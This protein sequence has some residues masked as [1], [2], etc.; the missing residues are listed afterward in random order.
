MLSTELG[1]PLLKVY[2]PIAFRKAYLNY[3]CCLMLLA[4]HPWPESYCYMG[5]HSA[6]WKKFSSL[7]Q[8]KELRIAARQEVRSEWL[9]VPTEK[10][11]RI[12]CLL[13]YLSTIYLQSNVQATMWYDSGN[14]AAHGMLQNI[15]SILTYRIFC[16]N[17][18]HLFKNIY[19]LYTQGSAYWSST[20]NI[21]KCY[22]KCC[23]NYRI[24]IAFSTMKDH[25]TCK[26]I[27]MIEINS[28]SE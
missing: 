23:N 12:Q 28:M 8:H 22:Y 3:Q 2:L 15:N 5:S 14:L 26:D 10:D 6:C 19:N 17:F 1:L 9:W 16:S 25:L 18:L 7:G 13:Q 27:I 20:S 11:R 4:I 21:I 24:M